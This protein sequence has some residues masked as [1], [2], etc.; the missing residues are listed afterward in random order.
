MTRVAAT[1]VMNALSVVKPRTILKQFLK[2]AHSQMG[3][4][5]HQPIGSGEFS[6]FMPF[7]LLDDVE[8]EGK[9]SGFGDHPHRGQETMTYVLEG[10]IVHQDSNGNKGILY[11]GDMQAMRAGSGIMH[12]ETPIADPETNCTKGIQLW[13]ALPESNLNDA[14]AYK[15]IKS[16][17][18]PVSSPTPGVNVKVIAGESFGASAPIWTRAPVWYFDITLASKA[19][20]ITHPVPEHWGAFVHVIEGYPSISGSR[21]RPHET[22]F[23]KRDGEGVKI[24]NQSDNEARLLLIAGDP[25]EGQE[26]H[27]MGPF[28]SASSAGISKAIMDYQ[29]GSNGFERASTWK[30]DAVH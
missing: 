19:G 29:R 16:T 27:R 10:S 17:E 30:S 14:S 1:A 28:V 5:I 13:V 12:N 4:K 25:L 2:P 8:S 9:N 22:F 11:V 23:M 15:D 3:I 21:G 7:L 18:C 24:E 26:V 6:E 20:P